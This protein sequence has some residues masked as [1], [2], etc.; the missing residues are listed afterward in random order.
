MRTSVTYT[1]WGGCKW[2]WRTEDT[3]LGKKLTAIIGPFVIY[4]YYSKPR[5]EHEWRPCVVDSFTYGEKKPARI[6]AHCKDWEPLTP[7]QFYALFG[8]SF[9]VAANFGMK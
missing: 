8:E 3:R 7:G 6:C 1:G 9:Y 4:W 5:C 2:R